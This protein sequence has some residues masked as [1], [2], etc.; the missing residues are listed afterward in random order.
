VQYAEQ[1]TPAV[2]LYVLRSTNW[3]GLL[4]SVTALCLALRRLQ[5]T[6]AHA[7]LTGLNGLLLT[8]ALATTMITTFA[9]AARWRG[10]LAPSRVSLDG[11]L[12]SIWIGQLVNSLLPGRLGELARMYLVGERQQLGKAKVLSTILLEKFLDLA[13]LL[14]LLLSLLVVSD[15]LLPPWFRPS[16]LPLAAITLVLLMFVLL[17]SRGYN[18]LQRS[19]VPLP[20]GWRQRLLRG[21]ESLRIPDQAGTLAHGL[22]WSVLVWALA[23]STN[24]LLLAA[25]GLHHT[26]PSSTSIIILVAIHLGA[27]LPT[28]PAQ[29]GVFHYLCVLALTSLGVRHSVALSYAVVLHLIVYLPIITLGSLGLWRENRS[30]ERLGRLRSASSGS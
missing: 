15:E 10:L 6:D 14:G 29:I 30:L 25:F 8:L 20:T 28:A 18:L 19:S 4:L 7:A 12:F 21:A 5:W 27:L 13:M 26:L 16:A 1:K 17:T 3:L 24:Y 9:K 11:L 2:I 22:I 23:A